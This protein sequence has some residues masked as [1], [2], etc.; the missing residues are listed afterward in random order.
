MLMLLWWAS[1]SA[2]LPLSR[3]EDASASK[4]FVNQT[5]LTSELIELTMQL[6]RYCSTVSSFGENR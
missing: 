6:L 1:D 3:K 2:P 5:E 4:K